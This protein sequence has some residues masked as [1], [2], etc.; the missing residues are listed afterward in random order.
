MKFLIAHN[1]DAKSLERLRSVSPEIE[2]VVARPVFVDRWRGKRSTQM[3]VDQQQV[4][5]SV[6]NRL[7]LHGGFQ[8]HLAA[9]RE[10]LLSWF[11]PRSFH[12]QRADG[13][14]AQQQSQT[15]T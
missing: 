7:D 9:L 8:H 12:G 1:I 4:S 6:S 3:M 2:V 13:G 14:N 5:I 15:G 10:A 11:L